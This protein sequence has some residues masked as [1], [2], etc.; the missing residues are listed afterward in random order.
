LRVT[1]SSAEP[2]AWGKAKV[3]ADFSK[4][5]PQSPVEP[6]A[7]I[8]QHL[9]TAKFGKFVNEK[10]SYT[11]R[12]ES[13]GGFKLTLNGNK[14]NVAVQVY[15]EHNSMMYG[16]HDSSFK[17]LFTDKITSGPF[18]AKEVVVCTN[19]D[20][21]GR[22][23]EPKL[24]AVFI[25]DGETCVPIQIGTFSNRR[26]PE[27]QVFEGVKELVEDL[28]SKEI[29]VTLIRQKVLLTKAFNN[30]LGITGGK[31]QEKNRTNVF[32]E[33]KLVPSKKQNVLFGAGSGYTVITRESLNL[34]NRSVRTLNPELPPLRTAGPRYAVPIH[35]ER[36]WEGLEYLKLPQV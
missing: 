26:K 7:L 15:D 34:Q 33:N 1:R 3:N 2:S 31:I 21:P 17:G 6:E 25:D 9:G 13:L 5:N 16:S 10:N 27:V 22:N 11:V 20:L 18:V 24:Y 14:Q 30:A 35:H 29:P 8:K 32:Q 19:Q 12:D 4:D 23:T 28:R 36:K